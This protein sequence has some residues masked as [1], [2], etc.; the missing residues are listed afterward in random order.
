MRNIFKKLKHRLLRSENDVTMNISIHCSSLR[1]FLGVFTARRD[2]Y[3]LYFLRAP[4]YF[5]NYKFLL[6]KLAIR[7]V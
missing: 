5:F 7:V 1:S 2:F 3:F 6:R 4:F